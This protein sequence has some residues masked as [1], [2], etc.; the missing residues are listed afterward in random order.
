VTFLDDRVLLTY[1]VEEERTGRI[2]SRFRSLPLA[3]FYTDERKRGES[4]AGR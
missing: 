3:W 1:Y 4:P 2:G